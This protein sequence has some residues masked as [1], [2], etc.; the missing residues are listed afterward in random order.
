M[1][2]TFKN[3]KMDMIINITYFVYIGLLIYIA[4]KYS[5]RLFMPFIAAFII[6]IM[7]EPFVSIFIKKLKIKRNLASIICL[8]TFY[9]V[10]FALGTFFCSLIMDSISSA[11]STVPEIINKIETF[12]ESLKKMFRMIN[13]VFLAT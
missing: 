7:L 5:F 13:I 6:S 2:N 11:I 12:Y 3:K 1:S 8:L 10:I 4:F 9:M